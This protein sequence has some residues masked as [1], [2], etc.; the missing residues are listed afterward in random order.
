MKYQ[1]RL[2][3]AEKERMS[4]RA[5]KA[6]AAGGQEEHSLCRATSAVPPWDQSCSWALFWDALPSLGGSVFQ[7]VTMCAALL[8]ILERHQIRLFGY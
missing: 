6:G 3:L 5:R 2:T 8:L 7:F 4:Y 1:L